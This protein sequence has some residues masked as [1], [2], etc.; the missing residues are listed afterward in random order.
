MMVMPLEETMTTETPRPLLSYDDYAAIDDG[1]HYQVIDGILIRSPSPSRR[2]QRVQLKLL[3]AL[4]THVEHHQLGE[5][6][7][8][9]YDVVLRR[10]RPAV[11]MQPDLVF[12]SNERRERNTPDN[13]Q[14]AP[15]LAVEVLSPG[16]AR[17]DM[18]RKRVR[19][20]EYGVRE[21]WVVPVG[22]D[23]IEVYHPEADGPFGKPTIYVPGERLASPLLPG[24]SLDVAAMF[25]PEDGTMSYYTDPD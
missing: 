15:D 16:T 13:I 20:A 10:E 3:V 24:I 22:M 14:G 2:H 4:T 11:V 21:L 1:L 19:Y 6:F 25:P 17:L 12:V 5:V 7:C 18:S 8:P 9:P 23:R